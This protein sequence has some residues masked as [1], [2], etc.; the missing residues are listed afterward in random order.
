[1]QVSQLVVLFLATACF[2]DCGDVGVPT[3]NA[4]VAVP[5]VDGDHGG[6]TSASDSSSSSDD[7]TTAKKEQESSSSDS[8]GFDTSS[9]EWSDLDYDG[10]QDATNIVKTSN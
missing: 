2:V 10:N 5:R 3:S 6:E 4:V 9:N 7:S 1:M 8:D